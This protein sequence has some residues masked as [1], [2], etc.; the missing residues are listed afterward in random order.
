MIQKKIVKTLLSR[1]PHIR[2]FIVAGSLIFIC[3]L[4]SQLAWKN[5]ALF[6]FLISSYDLVSAKG[7]VYRLVT[8]LFLHSDL[9]HLLSNSYMLFFLSLFVFGTLTFS[10]LGTLGLLLFCL[11]GGVLVNWMT[12]RSYPPDVGLLGISGLVYFLAGFWF[13]NFLLID[14]RRKLLARLLRVIGV[15][16]VVLFP[17]TFEE[18]VSYLAHFHGFWIG[19]LFGAGYFLMFFKKIRSYEEWVVEPIEE[20]LTEEPLP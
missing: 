4:T 3:V 8:A 6:E 9:G 11:S 19:A 5:K 13:V 18:R 15:S 17:T 16:L 10:F 7:E 20:D 12:L 14:R 2:G 1:A